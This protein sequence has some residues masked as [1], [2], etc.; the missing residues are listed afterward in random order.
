[1]AS[2]KPNTEKSAPENTVE[3]VTIQGRLCA[4]PVLRHTKSGRAVTN[5][6]IA[7]NQPEPTFHTVVLWGRTAEVTAQYKRK[8]HMVEIT[9]RPQ[10]TSWTDRD[11]NER[12]G[13][14]I[15][16]FRIQ[17]MSR[18][19]SRPPRARSR[20]GD[21]RRHHRER[22]AMPRSRISPHL[23][24]MPGRIQLRRSARTLDRRRP[25]LRSDLA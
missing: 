18:Q 23:R 7:V 19:A 20:N 21:P 12:Q 8:G 15:N 14:Q 2:K 11:G 17:F 1:M 5:I 16:A 3:P 10:T 4:D 6:R 13:E 22:G 24:R 25:A 9:G